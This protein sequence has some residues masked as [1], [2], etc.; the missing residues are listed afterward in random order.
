MADVL[1]LR[2]TLR[3]DNAVLDT[4]QQ[5]LEQLEELIGDPELPPSA[6]AGI[7]KEVA[8]QAA[9]VRTATLRRNSALT[10]YNAAVQADPMHST[11]A[12][13]PLVLLPVRIETAYLPGAAGTDLVV[14]V[15]PDD[16][17]VDSHEP[18]L[19]A[20]ELA[21]GT[22]YWNAV[23]GAGSNQARL[24][25][26]W[27]ILLGQLKPS[28][29]SW[30]MGVLTPSVP[31]PADETPVDQ[32]QPAPPLPTVATRAGNFTRAAHT[33]LLPDHWHVLGFRD[34]NELF[35]VDGSPIPDTLNVSFGPPGTSANSSD[36][37]FDDDSRWL[38][39][40]NA[41]I[42]VGMAIR[43]PLTGPD[44]ANDLSVDQLFV[45]GVSAQ[46]APED[47]LTRLEATL[48]AHQ[49]TNG[50]GF[51][52]PGTPTNNTSATRSA[53]QSAPQPPTPSDIEAARGQYQPGS[54]QNAA[55]VARVLSIDGAQALCLAENGLADQQTGV[56]LLQ[57]QLWSALEAKA[58]SLL[59]WQWVIPPGS[60]GGWKLNDNPAI[61]T[62]LS[63]HVQGWVRSRGTLPVLR[64]GNQPYG[65]LP[66]SSLADWVP[67]ADD[68]TAPLVDWLR[69][70]LTYFQAAVGSVPRVIV[71]GQ[72]DPDSSVAD[73]L[74]RLPVSSTIMLR[75]DGDP[76]SSAIANQPLPAA[77]IPGLPV[78][79]ELFYSAPA[80]SASRMPIPVVGDGKAD[81]GLLLKW[82]ELFNDSIAVLDQTMAYQD[83]LT[84]YQPL[85]GASTFPGA[86]PPDL[87]TTL[88][89]DALTDPL[90]TDPNSSDVAGIVLG[91]AFYEEKKDDPTFQQNVQNLLPKAKA[92]VAQFADVC[93]LDPDS[94]DPVLR[95]LLDIASHRF[96]AWVTSLAARRLDQSRA[97]KPAGIVLG[98]YGWVED[99]A[100]RTDLTAVATPP[101]GFDSVFASDRQ[102]YIHAPSMQHAATA[103]VLRAGYDSHPDPSALAVNLVSA[104]VRVADWL[105]EGVRN[106]Q[107]VGALL[108]YRFERGLHDANLDA[109]IETL[110]AQHPLPLPTGPDADENGAAAREAIAARNVVDGL[111]CIRQRAAVIAAFQPGDQVTAAGLLD[112]LADAFD[113]FG[114]L[115]LAESVHHLVGGN[116]LRAGMSADMVGRGEQIPERF[117]VVRTP[118][119]G[120][121]LTWQIG[122]LLPQSWRAATTGW[123]TGRPRAQVESH[124][125]AWVSTMLGNASM[126]QITCTVTG[127]DGSTSTQGIGLDAIGLCALDVICES[128]GEQSSLERRIV[129][130][131]TATQL[132][133]S[134]VTVVN[135]PASDGSL[136]FAEL[137]AFAARIR[138]LLSQAIALGPQPVQGPDASPALGIDMN[139]LASRVGILQASLSSAA[140]TLTT[141]IDTLTAAEG[142][143]SA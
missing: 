107:T 69:S 47:A 39:D 93:G 18:E 58:L 130:A 14:R 54:K 141:A 41:A 85:L 21:A 28:R 124:V 106:G 42:A 95:E 143:D 3:A 59:Y 12:G 53:W 35:N 87:F 135:T 123:N 20:A 83:W 19:T 10:A 75:Q 8:A 132:A 57:R 23:W 48:L 63:D 15:Y 127:A 44:F 140:T 64:V 71:G 92:F 7:R 142:A 32:P 29:A 16:I 31:R 26:A 73:V 102:K 81:Q 52:P 99:L 70:F 51:L 103:A 117:D 72:S 139:E 45:L 122:A 119:S 104:R 67:A 65:L 128:S 4:E 118:R 55:L 86:P 61:T 30:T 137:L 50:L 6:Q 11:D 134:V 76:T 133:G 84:E 105:A 111:D 25:A 101:A 108:G 33:T 112:D 80:D 121:P 100:P 17:H 115:L 90:N 36:L 5:K 62:M 82:L 77:P 13:L 96:D 136:G 98:A 74:K 114:D 138:L 89:Q 40:L 97:A 110:R 78:N 68:P 37:P 120:R 109:M 116:P 2:A 24:D 34:G 79:S 60:K 56:F 22:A 66:T 91:A 129:D 88:F 43:I 113:A 9:V 49:Y 1:A 38:V 27:K 94:Y 125:D 126:W 131:V 46:I